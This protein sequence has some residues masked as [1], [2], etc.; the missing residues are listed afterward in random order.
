MEKRHSFTKVSEDRQNNENW[1][2]N[3]NDLTLTSMFFTQNMWLKYFESDL[4]TLT[5]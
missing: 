3:S 2:W 4:Y 5:V 1:M